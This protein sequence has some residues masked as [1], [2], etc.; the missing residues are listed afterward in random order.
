MIRTAVNIMLVFM[1]GGI[2][3]G[4]GIPFLV[5][6]IYCGLLVV[7]YLL[8]KNFTAMLSLRGARFAAGM[9]IA[10]CL[11]TFITFAIGLLLFRIESLDMFYLLIGNLLVAP[12]SLSM[13]AVDHVLRLL[14]FLST[15]LI[16]EI[17]ELKVKPFNS[18]HQWVPAL[19][20][21]LYLIGI[22]LF[23]VGGAFR[24]EQF[25]YFQF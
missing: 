6:G 11:Y 17:G 16:I 15:L 25:F 14:L 10:G 21:A 12:D 5:W 13:P 20:K 18:L 7:F 8:S 9:K 22:I 2:W 4:A 1:V 19:R 24:T 3:H 23:I